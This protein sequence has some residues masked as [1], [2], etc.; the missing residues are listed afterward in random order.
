MIYKFKF[1]IYEDSN[2][3]I[4]EIGEE[5]GDF[6]KAWV[7]FFNKIMEYLQVKNLW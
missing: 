3:L 5:S 1:G 4:H 2:T 6:M 7:T